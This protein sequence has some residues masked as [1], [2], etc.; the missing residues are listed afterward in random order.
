MANRGRRPAYLPLAGFIIVLVLGVVAWF[1]APVVIAWLADVVPYVRGTELPLA[2]TRPIFTALIVVLALLL[3]SLIAALSAPR[4]T[5]HAAASTLERD[6]A[7][8]RLRQKAKRDQARKPK[9]LS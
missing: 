1:A 2:T 9:G 8:L 4:D 3:V 6:R 5:K 7:S